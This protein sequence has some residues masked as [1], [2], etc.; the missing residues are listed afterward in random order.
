MTINPIR[1][2]ELFDKYVR[3][4]ITA[5]EFTEFW[6]LVKEMQASDT[7]N[8]KL[9][10][11]WQEWETLAQPGSG[12]DK[13]KVFHRIMEKGREREID[14]EKLRAYPVARRLRRL[15]AAAVVLATLAGFYLLYIRKANPVIPSPIY[16]AQSPHTDYTRHIVLPDSS[17]VVLHAGS[18]LDYPAVFPDDSREVTLTGEAYFDVHHDNKKPFIIH[19]GK[20][21]TVVLGTAFNISSDGNQV[22]V[23]VTGGKVRVENGKKVLAELTPNQQIVYRVPEDATE[24]A[25][26][27]A[28]QLVTNWTKKDMVFDGDSFGDIAA[29]ISKRY[30]VL[31]RFK[32]PE[33]A[34]CLIVASFSGTETLDNV[35]GTLCTIR[36]A[37]YNQN[38]E[39]R[40]VEIDGKG[41]E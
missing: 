14:F 4:N 23:S 35:L 19:T 40:E 11:L 38:Q 37:S 21:R 24:K 1:L 6:R 41:C 33:L 5:E 10:T 18:T 39:N 34:K 31:I 30:G 15:A 3:G 20:I 17:T 25:T 2:E 29:V 8:T 36:N 7:L 27:N 26:V 9:T 13:S 12:P 16:A 32:N 28:E 22:T